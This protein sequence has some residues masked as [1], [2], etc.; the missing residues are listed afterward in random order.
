M[1]KK[2]KKK[3]SESVDVHP[4]SGMSVAELRSILSAYPDDALFGYFWDDLT[5]EF[6]VLFLREETD[7]EYQARLKRNKHTREVARKKREADK[8]R[9]RVL[10]AQREADERKLFE[11]LKEKYG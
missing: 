8:E 6:Q 4:W 10:A 11:G 3:V 2:K 9:E 5:A 7:E 1:T